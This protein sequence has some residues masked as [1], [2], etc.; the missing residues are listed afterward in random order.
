MLRLVRAIELAL[1]ALKLDNEP[2]IFCRT[3]RVFKRAPMAEL[4]AQQKY[5][6][7][8]AERPRMGKVPSYLNCNAPA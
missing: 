7:L 8:R 6:P 2:T 5:S 3:L 1:A 4:I